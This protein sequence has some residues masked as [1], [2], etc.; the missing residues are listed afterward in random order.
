MSRKLHG[1]RA[2]RG[3]AAIFVTMSLVPTMGVLG[4]VVDVGWSFYRKEAT[5]TAA[6]A[7]SNAAA[8]AGLNVPSYACSTGVPCQGETA[9]PA[10]PTSP[11]TDLIG[12]AC[13]YAKQNGF[14]NSGRQTVT[15]ETNNTGLPVAGV[16]NTAYWVRVK[17]SEKIP[18]LFSAV[19]GNTW[20]TVKTESTDA[21]F[22]QANGACVYALD[23]HAAGAIT[24]VGNTTVSASCGMYDDSDNS[25]A[26][27]VSGST[28]VTAGT[29]KV[30]GGYTTN[31]GA[32]VN[33]VPTTDAGLVP[34]PFGAVPPP[35]LPVGHGCDSNGV[36]GAFS[37]TMRSE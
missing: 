9:C 23:R 14:V 11:P 3:Q 34:D 37:T 7:A 31:G 24:N 12:T 8:T 28:T 2:L 17:V 13:L 1:R 15:V 4:L 18:Q 32:T 19:L 20:S 5:K 29:I 16:T 33:P 6:Q 30:V 36:N 35:S 27:S 10:S 21:I 25:S 26:L 22:I